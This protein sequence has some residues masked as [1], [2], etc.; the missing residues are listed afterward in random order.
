[1][2]A[3]KLP[4]ILIVEDDIE[5]QKFLKIFLKKCF[6]VEVCDNAED[7]YA[8]LNTQ[9]IDIILMDISLKGT[10][11]GLQLTKEL[12]SHPEFGSLPIIGLSAHAF[13]KDKD[14]AYNA[15]IDFF[16]TKPVDAKVLLDTLLSSL[17]ECNKKTK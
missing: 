11:D 5:N 1:M 13:Q 15:G 3:S 17:A 9:P 12:K 10:K 2:T 4:T 14:N 16:M 7:C 6:E 8:I